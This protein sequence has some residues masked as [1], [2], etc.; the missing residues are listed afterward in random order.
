MAFKKYRVKWRLK[1]NGKTYPAGEHTLNLKKEEEDS[2]IRA[3][4]I[5]PVDGVKE[6]ETSP[7]G[8]ESSQ[9]SS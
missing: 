7:E 8:M 1:R 4:V 2:L 9:S 3:G 6:Q 5:E